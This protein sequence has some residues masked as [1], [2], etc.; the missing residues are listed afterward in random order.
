MKGL[1]VQHIGP[2][3]YL[4]LPISRLRGVLGEA[5]YLYRPWIP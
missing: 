1:L 3:L 2:V 5:A 4:C